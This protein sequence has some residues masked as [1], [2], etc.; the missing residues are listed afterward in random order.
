M[1]YWRKEV[2]IMMEFVDRIWNNKLLIAIL[3]SNLLLLIASF[4]LF[5]LTITFPH[6]LFITV[7]A[8][9]IICVYILKDIGY[10]F[11]FGSLIVMMSCYL[12]F[13]FI[14]YE[15]SISSYF[16]ALIDSNIKE[17]AIVYLL[18][19]FLISGNFIM[20]LSSKESTKD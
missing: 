7:A 1:Q 4:I 3:F 10:F 14:S 17:N 16:W 5:I 13:Y 9:V 18:L 20:Y 6:L 11:A 8:A 15:G 19:L 2:V 12:S